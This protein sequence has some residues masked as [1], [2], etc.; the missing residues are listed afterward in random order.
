MSLAI[1]NNYATAPAKHATLDDF[2]ET[3]IKDQAQ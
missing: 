3:E 2:V 1:V